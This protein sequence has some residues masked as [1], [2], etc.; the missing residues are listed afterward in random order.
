MPRLVACGSRDAAFHDF[1]LAVQNRWGGYVAMWIDSEDPVEEIEK[2][3]KHLA[4]RDGWQKPRSVNDD[5]VLLMTTCME[6]LIVADLSA[7]RA[8]YKRLQESALTPQA[9]LESRHRHEVQDG[10]ARATRGCSNA[11]RKGARSF[12]PLSS[13]S[14]ETLATHLPSFART[15]RILEQKL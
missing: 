2:V 7:C 1:K 13:L 4:K 8:H 6:T 14:P 3:W 11:Y 15:L 5:Q 9:N 12:E 10:L